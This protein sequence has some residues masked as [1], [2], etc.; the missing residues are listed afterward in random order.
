MQKPAGM[1]QNYSKWSRYDKQKKN[2][3]KIT[4]LKA[5]NLTENSDE[6]AKSNELVEYEIVKDGSRLEELMPS[7]MA[8]ELLDV[9]DYDVINEEE[10]QM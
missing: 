10:R 2:D 6:E 5:E 4:K 1:A 8:D 3:W 9:E 7:A